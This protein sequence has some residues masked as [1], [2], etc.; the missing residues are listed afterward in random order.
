MDAFVA[1]VDDNVPSKGGVGLDVGSDTEVLQRPLSGP[2]GEVEATPEQRELLCFTED[3]TL[4]VS[5]SHRLDQHVLVYVDRLRR[6]GKQFVILPTTLERIKELYASVA[7]APDLDSS[8]MQET[9]MGMIQEA[10]RSGASDIHIVNR[11]N[12]SVIRIRVNGVLEDYKR[13]RP[14]EGRKMATTIYQ[15]MLDV[16]GDAYFNENKP[17]DGRLRSE[18]VEHTGLYGARVATRPMERGHLTVMRLLYNNMAEVTLDQLGYLPEQVDMLE[19]MCQN[20]T[21]INILS[22]ATG[23][24][25]SLTLKCALELSSRM[26]DNSVHVLTL[27]DPPEYSIK[28]AVQTPVIG[29]D[30]PGAIANAM[31]LDPDIMLVGEMRDFESATAA[32]RAGMT[33]HGVWTTLHANDTCS[34]LDR[35]KDMGVDLGLLTDPALVTGLINQSLVRKVCRHC[36]ISYE[37]AAETLTRAQR[38][39]IES[40]CIVENIRMGGPGCKHCRNGWA[41]RTLVAEVIRPNTTFMDIYKAEGK[42]AARQYWLT[43]MVGITKAE[44]V[45]RRVNE[46]TI[47]PIAAEKDVGFTLDRAMG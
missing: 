32:F 25:K 1:P 39:R 16:A 35:L 27:E 40:K 19:G 18:F 24:G 21:G 11:H 5:Q 7:A 9:V 13:L 4:H 31:R 42:T 41:G 17:Q 10:T 44:H 6:L 12:I 26:F 22:G 8:A 46:G 2:K 38:A 14:V 33:G 28:G 36:S 23:S 30:W 34:A 3:G 29:Q 15:S 47:D 43:E 37:E 45:I 20:K